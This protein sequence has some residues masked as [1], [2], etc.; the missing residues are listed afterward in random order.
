MA[1]EGGDR[2]YVQSLERGF[3]VLLAFD[4]DL[5]RPTLA[6]LAAKTGFSRPAVRRLLLTLQR[7]GYVANDGSRWTLTPRVLSIAQH[8][9][10]TRATIELAQPHLLRQA[11]RTGES[12]SLAELDGHEAVY[13]ARVPVR[14]IMSINVAVGTRVPAYATSMGRVLLAWAG[15]ETI[16]RFLEEAEMRARTPATVTDPAELRQRLAQ[17]R[18]QGF[19]IVDGELE[20]GLVSAAVPVRDA[21]GRVVAAL[22]SSTSAGRLAPEKLVEQT[23]PI[24]LET[25]AAISADLGYDATVLPPIRDGFY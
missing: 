2:D 15:P 23:V 10:A 17:V 20:E 7:L 13:V 12:A 6:E 21:G 24:L 25:A 16:T 18:E 4:E 14:R 1:V 3:A 8:Y 19:S 5:T 22:A 9:T 11:E